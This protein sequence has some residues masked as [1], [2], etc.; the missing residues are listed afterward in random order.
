MQGK[1]KTLEEEK[2]KIEKDLK[3]AKEDIAKKDKRYKSLQK[4]KEVLEETLKKAKGE[5]KDD[6]TDT[7]EVKIPDKT[8]N[9]NVINGKILDFN[10]ADRYYNAIVIFPKGTKLPEDFLLFVFNNKGEKV[11]RF[12]VVGTSLK[13]SIPDI[14]KYGG[15]ITPLKATSIVEKNYRVSTLSKMPDITK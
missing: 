4:E 7:D 13:S 15:R 5:T 6:T 12:Q 11:G 1:L 2:A 8:N 3:D 10:R 14:V 9:P